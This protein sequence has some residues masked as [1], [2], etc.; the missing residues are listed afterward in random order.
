MCCDL[1]ETGNG[2]VEIDGTRNVLHVDSNHVVA[3]AGSDP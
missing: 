1:R 3:E 2:V